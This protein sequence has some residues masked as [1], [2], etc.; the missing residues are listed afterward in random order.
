ME[1]RPLTACRD[2][3]VICAG[4]EAEE[5]REGISGSFWH[6]MRACV[7]IVLIRRTRTRNELPL[8]FIV[9]RRELGS[10]TSPGAYSRSAFPVSS[11][12]EERGEMRDNK[13][14]PVPSVPHLPG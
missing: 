8:L 12:V 9:F 14:P 10:W 4:E 6:S 13:S 2:A 1:I 3:E 7:I 5:T 11:G